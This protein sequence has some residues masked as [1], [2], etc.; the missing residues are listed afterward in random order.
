MLTFPPEFDFQAVVATE[1]YDNQYKLLVRA[2]QLLI[3]SGTTWCPRTTLRT[4]PLNTSLLSSTSRTLLAPPLV[5]LSLVFALNASV[6]PIT[7]CKNSYISYVV[8]DQSSGTFYG[9][10]SAQKGSGT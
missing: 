4:T 5:P 10:A 8:Y 1:V 9:G 2:F 6:I 7:G 3:G